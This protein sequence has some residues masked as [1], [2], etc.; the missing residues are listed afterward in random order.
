MQ[1][2]IR[3]DMS[4]IFTNS[5]LGG[6]FPMLGGGLN[7]LGGSFVDVPQIRIVPIV[8]G[9]SDMV[10]ETGTTIGFQAS[11]VDINGVRFTPTSIPTITITD[12][13]KNVVIS[14]E[15][16]DPIA[17][18][19]YYFEYQTNVDDYPG[20]LTVRVAAEIQTGKTISNTDRF[21]LAQ[22]N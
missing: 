20:T 17:V 11:F 2:K 18:G 16:M 12:P 10:F 19:T 15:D 6:T 4:G 9:G 21:Y 7:T 5:T 14:A 8:G 1:E 3:L 22:V 13:R